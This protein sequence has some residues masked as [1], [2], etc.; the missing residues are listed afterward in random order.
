MS[1]KVESSKKKCIACD[2][3]TTHTRTVTKLNWLLHIVLAVI[4]AGAWLL[5]VLVLWLFKSAPTAWVCSNDHDDAQQEVLTKA[6][7][8]ETMNAVKG[9]IA[10]VVIAF[11]VSLF[12]V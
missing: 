6:K 5:V 4:T 12:V 1:K 2:S 7:S 11:V 3:N 10:L 9:F 8:V